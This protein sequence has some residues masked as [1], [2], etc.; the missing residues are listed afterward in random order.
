[1]QVGFSLSDGQDLL[2]MAT[3]MVVVHF[4]L[5]SPGLGDPCVR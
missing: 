4:L 1:V 5:F 2:G 3:Q